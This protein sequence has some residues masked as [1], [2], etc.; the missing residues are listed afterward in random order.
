VL[1]KNPYW[2]D[3]P[4][5]HL[6]HIRMA[7]IADTAS[8]LDEYREG[9]LD[10]LD[11]YG[12]LTSEDVDL[13]R[14]DPVY[15][16]Q[17]HLVRTPCTHYY[18]F[19]T[20]KAPFNEPLVR[21]A[22]AAAVDRETLVTSVV[23]LGEPAKWF[24]RPGV[25]A[26]FDVSEK[27]GIPFD[28]NKAR[29]Y[30][31]QAGYDKKRF[32]P[33]TLAVNTTDPNEQIAETVVQMWKNNLGVEVSVKAQDWKTYLKTL[34]EDPPQMFR[35]GWCGY[36]PDAANFTESVFRSGS[37][38]N[39]TRWSSPRLDQLIGEAARETDV[40]RRQGL[41]KSAEKL[42]IEDTIAIIPLW[43][44]TRAVLTR[45]NVQR[46]Y[47]ITDGYEHFEDWSLQ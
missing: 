5:V 46:T 17:L 24:T 6:D 16:K 40:N 26:S 20:T 18:G 3:A 22:F 4:N 38:D 42:L 30:L 21:R 9:N 45:P 25:Y 8:A 39:F 43:W 32:G 37:P 7:M 14:E 33:I 44:S 41:Y 34:S 19:N 27:L 31:R 10:S 15:G 2:V 28:V 13:V 23:K 35:L 29:E 12:G 36:F 11:P 1:Q 47:A